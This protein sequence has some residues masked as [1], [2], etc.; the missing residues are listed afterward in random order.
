MDKAKK[1]YLKKKKLLDQAKA[2]KLAAALLA[3][4]YPASERN[5]AR[6]DVL[7]VDLSV[8]GRVE[9]RIGGS[10]PALFLTVIGMAELPINARAVAS[11]TS[12]QN[13]DVV[14][15]DSDFLK[16]IIIS[17]GI[18]SNFSSTSFLIFLRIHSPKG[19]PKPFF[20]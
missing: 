14:G 11:R 20:F 16:K 8:R 12:G 7:A 1:E 5:G 15:Q 9:V 18:S 4:Q 2:K 17:S 19:M 3:A 13:I 6:I 10:V